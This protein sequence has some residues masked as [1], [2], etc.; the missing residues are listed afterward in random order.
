MTGFSAP[1]RLGASETSAG[2]SEEVRLEGTRRLCPAAAAAAVAAAAA[3]AAAVG[4][5]F[6]D[7]VSSA[8]DSG[9]RETLRKL[10]V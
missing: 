3:A 7:A 10:E 4:V 5:G 2:S 9:C 6:E 1:C 8:W